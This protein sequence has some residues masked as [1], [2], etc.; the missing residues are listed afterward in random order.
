MF[1]TTYKNFIRMLNCDQANQIEFE[2]LKMS[3][4]LH[5]FLYETN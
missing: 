4:V 5:N 1:S 3:V 2:T